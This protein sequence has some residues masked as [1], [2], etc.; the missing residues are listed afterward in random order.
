MN[1][2][3]QLKVYQMEVTKSQRFKPNKRS[4]KCDVTYIISAL[5]LGLASQEVDVLTKSTNESA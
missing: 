5:R 4:N 2:I 3:N 1:V